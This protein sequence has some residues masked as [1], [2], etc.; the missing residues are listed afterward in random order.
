MIKHKCIKCGAILESPES[1]TGREDICPIC[2]QK[3]IVIQKAKSG[4]SGKMIVACSFAVGLLIVISFSLGGAMNSQPSQHNATETKY[5]EPYAASPQKII[6]KPVKKVQ[7][8]IAAKPQKLPEA[9]P[10]PVI[11]SNRNTEIQLGSERTKKD[12][13]LQNDDQILAMERVLARMH[14]AMNSLPSDSFTDGAFFGTDCKN[15]AEQLKVID[16]SD[17]PTDFQSAY[18]ELVDATEANGRLFSLQHI[19]D[20]SDSRN[21]SAEFNEWDRKAKASALRRWQACLINLSTI[22]QNAGVR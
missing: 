4:I 1:M 20:A 13:D 17:C 21:T 3:F 11:A 9:K 5:T 10:I 19:E 12:A 7:P 15:L 8:V 22:T 18:K 16:V 14:Q 6:S 2:R